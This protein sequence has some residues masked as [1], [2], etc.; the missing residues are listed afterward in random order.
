MDNKIGRDVDEIGQ[1]APMRRTS[2]H[3]TTL[4]KKCVYSLP[5]GRKLTVI[6]DAGAGPGQNQ[7]VSFVRTEV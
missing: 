1:E 7:Q 2:G 4:L 6:L 5:S 3:V